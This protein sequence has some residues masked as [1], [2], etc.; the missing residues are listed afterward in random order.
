[1]TLAISSAVVIDDALGPPAA[2]AIAAND[3]D[4]WIEIVAANPEVQRELKAALFK[5]SD[6]DLNELLEDLTGNHNRLTELWFLLQDNALEVAQLNILFHTASM[7]YKAKSEKALAVAQELGAMFGPEKVLIFADIESASDALASADIAFVDFYL[8]NEEEQDAALQRIKNSA[9]VLNKPKLLFFMSSM[10]SLEVQYSVRKLVG[11]RNAFFEVMRKGDIT[12]EFL[13]S[14]I[15]SKRAAYASNQSLQGVIEALTAATKNAI[16]EF[17]EECKDLEV[18]DLR[19]LDL[20][21]LDA[22]GETLPEYLTWLFS[23]A[24]AAKTRRIALPAAS[25][26]KIP[27]ESIGF[28]GQITQGKVLFDLFS[29]VVFGPANEAGKPIRFGE[30]LQSS[31]EATRYFL[32]LTPACDLQRCEPDKL[33]LCIEADAQF[34]SGHKA[35]TREKLYGKQS[36]GGLRHLYT[37][38]NSANEPTSTMLSWKNDKIVTYSVEELQGN[39]FKRIALMNEI[40]AQEVK[41]EALRILGRIG[42]Q[43]DPPPAVALHARLRWKKDNETC[44]VDTPQDSFISALLT[45][46]EYK[47]DHKVTRVQTIVLSDEFQIWVKNTVLNEF[48]D[49]P[50]PTKL[51]NCL[52]S[53]EGGKQFRLKNF[54][55]KEQDLRIAVIESNELE[56]TDLSGPLMEILLVD[57]DQEQK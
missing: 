40:F 1:M 18:H 30:L 31:Q 15:E 12:P 42:T 13:K 16:N 14:K 50:I 11:V 26:E 27:I 28:T 46:S 41:E 3:K 48:G 2:G 7:L 25:A 36:N 8:S 47:E 4:Q 43:I 22:E 37:T 32:V 56:T 9:S 49:T 23:E 35:L 45:Y 20:A 6:P 51:Q 53:L 38:Y 39:S 52:N 21:R 10:A 44:I 5:D 57:G 19:L 33:V 55:V 54:A 29:Q 24:L 34:Y 17:E